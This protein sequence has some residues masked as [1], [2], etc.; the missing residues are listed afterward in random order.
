[1]AW[2]NVDPQRALA[3]H[4]R[5][6][7]LDSTNI[8][9]LHQLAWGLVGALELDSAIAIE[10]LVTVRD[11]FY[12][13]P[14]SGLAE[15]LNFG[16]RPLE[17]AA[18]AIQ[19]TAIDSTSGSL[20]WQLAEANLLLHRPQLARTAATRAL[21]LGAPPVAMRV[22]VGLARLQMGDTAF[23]Q[24]ELAA[25]AE[26]LRRKLTHSSG[27]L[28]MLEAGFVSGGY[29]QLNQ[30]DS[31]LVWARRVAPGQRRY[32][33]IYFELHWFWDPV[34]ADPR[35]QALLAESRP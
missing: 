28:P 22:L 27:G 23:D 7:A 19:G 14:Y 16:R 17:A 5:A 10:R 33:R 6:V 4:R 25:A 15:M 12:A 35:F 11:P 9:A 18:I 20:Y 21:S 26:D 2:R 24:A 30:I 3:F 32:W 8:E 1:M 29:A 31:A 13:Y 34:R